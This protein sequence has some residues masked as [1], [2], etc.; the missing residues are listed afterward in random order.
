MN[1][2]VK[3]HRKSFMLLWLRVLELGTDMRHF[4]DT[5]HEWDLRTEECLTNTEGEDIISIPGQQGRRDP[6]V[7]PVPWA[8]AVTRV[9]GTEPQ[10]ASLLGG[11]PA[12][13]LPVTPPPH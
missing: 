8:Q 11:E 6:S 7:K 10:A 2:D 1:V 4:Q 9:P 12:S 13:P 3:F 5:G